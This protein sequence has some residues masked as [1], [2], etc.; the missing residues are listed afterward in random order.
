[1]EITYWSD[2]ACPFCYIGANSMK[3]A[4]KALNLTD[5][6]LTLMS[7]ELDPTAPKTAKASSD[8]LAP[9]MQQIEE[10][11][12]SNGLKMNLQGV[13]HVNS[14]DAHRLIKLAQKTGD[15]AVVSKLVD[16]LY[17]L[18]FVE[19][20]S[21]ADHDVLKSVATEVGLDADKVADVL[22][23]DQFEADV[24]RDEMSA[25]QS[26]VQGVPFFVINQKYAISGAQPY[27]VM[28]NA[29]KQ[30]SEEE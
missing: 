7:Y 18:Y 8:P 24:R 3:K 21:I 25:A 6:P 5:T 23:S 1:M 17:E 22:N 13:L 11:A 14:M 2:I 10:L 4:L 29:L 20:K 26:G 15:E 28:V 9:R 19:N 16:R 30:I 12:H 27:E